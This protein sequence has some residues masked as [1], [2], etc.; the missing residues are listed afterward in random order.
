MRGLPLS[1]FRNS[2]SK[3]AAILSR[4]SSECIALARDVP[5]AKHKVC[6]IHFLQ[7]IGLL[8]E[9]LDDASGFITEQDKNMG[10]FKGG[11]SL[12]ISFRG[13]MR[14]SI[15]PSVARTQVLES[16]A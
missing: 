9:R 6:V 10:Q 4:C 3:A 12:R 13:G 7:L 5:S 8:C 15:V 11:I 14:D 1:A 16:F 2:C